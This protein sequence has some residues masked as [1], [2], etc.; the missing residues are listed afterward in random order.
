MLTAVLVLAGVGPGLAVAAGV[1]TSRPPA[2]FYRYDGGNSGL[3]PSAAGSLTVNSART[4]VGKISF[5]FA[6]P[7][8]VK[9]PCVPASTTATSVL[10]N[11]KGSFRIS[12]GAGK[13]HGYWVVGVNRN[14]G[15]GD[16]ATFVVGSEPPVTGQF[17]LF[18]VGQHP[19]LAT[20]TTKFGGCVENSG[21]AFVWRHR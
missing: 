5:T 4:Q 21:D 16:R 9:L 15:G 3:S 14:G 17:N 20:L 10:V 11:I 2:G 1:H 18:F 7:S 12:P 13:E 19:D 6:L 8:G